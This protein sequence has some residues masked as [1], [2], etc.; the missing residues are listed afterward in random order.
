MEYRGG[1]W[2]TWPELP[3]DD[4]DNTLLQELESW[5]G[6]DDVPVS[7]DR[8]TDSFLLA[9]GD[10]T[11]LLRHNPMNGARLPGPAPDDD[12][13]T[14]SD[15]ETE[16]RYRRLCWRATGGIDDV[17]ESLGGSFFEIPAVPVPRMWGHVAEKD[18]VRR[19]GY[20]PEVDPDFVLIL[21]EY[22]NGRAAP[23]LAGVREAGV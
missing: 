17:I 15:D 22:E 18:R 21:R 10:T 8:F 5:A 1:Q 12:R 19:L 16:D 20:L 11:A 7:V 14:R 13:Y 4:T 6:R 2:V 3:L 9:H 23:I